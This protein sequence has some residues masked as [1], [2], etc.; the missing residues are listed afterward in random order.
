MT[1]Q[2]GEQSK[3]TGINKGNKE[4]GREKREGKTDRKREM[5]EKQEIQREEN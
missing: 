1:R 3:T 5:K 2:D 4:K